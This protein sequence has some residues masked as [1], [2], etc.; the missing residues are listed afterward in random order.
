MPASGNHQI[1]FF[2]QLDT[3]ALIRWY[4]RSGYDFSLIGL[5]A[6]LLFSHD[7]RQRRAH[8]IHCK[9][10]YEEVHPIQGVEHDWS[11]SFIYDYS[12]V[13]RGSACLQQEVR[14]SKTKKKKDRKKKGKVQN[15]NTNPPPNDKKRIYN[16]WKK[17]RKW[18]KKKSSLNFRRE[19]PT[20]ITNVCI[21]S[22]CVI[23]AHCCLHSSGFELVEWR[24]FWGTSPL[25][26]PRP[27]T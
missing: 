6:Q 13:K 14:Q 3:D 2:V 12:E 18:Q 16:D 17:T 9:F 4:P 1:S 20:A 25:P 5:R 27:G 22:T 23:P 21:E 26:P 8:S 19:L 10:F 7:Q 24:T 15:V 11:N